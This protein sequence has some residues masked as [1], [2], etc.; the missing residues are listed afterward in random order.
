MKLVNVYFEFKVYCSFC[1]ILGTCHLLE[2][3]EG[4]VIKFYVAKEEEGHLKFKLGFGKGH[5]FFGKHCCS[6]KIKINKQIKYIIKQIG[7]LQCSKH[8]NFNNDQPEQPNN[9]TT[10]HICQLLH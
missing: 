7:P 9:P 6:L 4:L 10:L 3:A 1:N 8:F 5:I 2:V